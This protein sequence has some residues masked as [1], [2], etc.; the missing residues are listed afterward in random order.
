MERNWYHPE[1]DTAPI[2]TAREHVRS[3]HGGADAPLPET[4]VLFEIG[5]AMRHLKKRY[6]TRVLSERLSC[7]L[8]NPSV[9]SLKGE[10]AVCFTRGGYGAPAA[11]DTVETLRALGVKRVILVG[12]C[13]VFAPGISVGDVLIPHKVLS[14]E[15]TSHHYAEN[16]LFAEPD[17]RLFHA[18]KEAFQGRF[19]VHTD[20]TVTSD[21]VYRQTFYKE[22]LWREQGC[23]GVDMEASAIL[24]VSACYELL[25]VCILLAS[26]CHPLSPQGQKWDWGA[27]DFEQIREAFVERAVSFACGL[28]PV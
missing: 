7:F 10:G 20:A 26:D 8:E 21:A 24:T 25:A 27:P 13:G 19:N 15:G 4:C 11:V 12:M 23:V 16:V 6:K 9:L 18:A 3:A 5:M 1:D 2:I 22:A 14:E 28:G 17:A